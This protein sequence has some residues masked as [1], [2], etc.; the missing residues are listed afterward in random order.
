MR[1]HSCNAH[2][3][4]DDEKCPYCGTPNPEAVKH[5]QEMH[6]F[7]REFFRTKSSVL[8]TSTETAQK[9]IRI[10]VVCILAVLVLIACIINGNSWSIASAIKESQAARHEKEYSAILDRYEAEGD[11]LSF[12]TFYNENYL[13]GVDAYDKYQHYYR[14]AS[15]YEYVYHQL[16]EILEE[17]S[18]ERN[19]YSNPVHFLCDY[20]DSYYTYLDE[21][22]YSF[23]EETGMYDEVHLQAVDRLTEKLEAMLKLVCSIPD[24]DME[25]F[26]NLSNAEKQVLIERSVKGHE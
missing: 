5:R 21:E 16:L 6:R 11:A 8:K 23:Y 15:N 22:H 9:S 14:A 3:S 24:E 4:I 7:S 18:T 12:A 2:L 10:T 1:C 26:R 20:I 25:N 13:Y 17:E 19:F